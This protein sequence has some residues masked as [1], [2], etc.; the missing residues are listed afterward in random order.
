MNEKKFYSFLL[1]Y[2]WVIC[3]LL[4]SV[5]LYEQALQRKDAQFQLLYEQLTHLQLKKKEV[6]ETQQ[7]LEL[8]INSQS[9]IAWIELTLMK[10]LGLTP[11]DYQKIYFENKNEWNS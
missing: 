6:L 4:L 5:I 10:V 3:F 11:E 2:W 9:D 1:K 7:N 8:Q